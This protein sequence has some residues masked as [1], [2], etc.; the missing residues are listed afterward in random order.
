MHRCYRCRSVTRSRYMPDSCDDY[1][2]HRSCRSYRF[3][4]TYYPRQ[5]NYCFHSYWL[6]WFM[7]HV[8]W[9]V[10]LTEQ[11]KIFQCFLKC[12][13]FS[14][15]FLNH[16]ILEKLPTTEN[17]TLIISRKNNWTLSNGHDVVPIKFCWK[18]LQ[19]N[20]RKKLVPGQ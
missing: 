14:Q 15:G 20:S 2:N 8:L 17:Q 13:A 12:I 3:L 19:R 10:S 9:Y 5:H 18:G 4:Q 11:I 6:N 16:L 7:W 1:S